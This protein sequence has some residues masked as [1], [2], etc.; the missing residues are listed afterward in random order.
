MSSAKQIDPL[1]ISYKALDSEMGHL[2]S[3]FSL[4]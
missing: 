1:I 4:A 3:N 2:V